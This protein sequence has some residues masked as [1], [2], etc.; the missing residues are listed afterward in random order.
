MYFTLAVSAATAGA[1][2]ALA[3]AARDADPRIMPLPGPARVAWQAADGR[4]AIL[5]W[6]H[7]PA[8]QPDGRPRD[9]GSAGQPADARSQ[10]GTIWAGADAVHARTGLAR[11]DPVYRA[12]V[13]GAVVLS[14]RAS[15]AAAVTGRL[16]DTDPVLVGAFLSLG[17]PVGAA[18]PFR[19]VYALAAG[20]RARAAGG[21]LRVHADPGGGAS[22][23]NGGDGRDGAGPAAVARALTE[24]VRPLAGTELSL[25]GGK[26]SRLVAAALV[27]AGVPFRARTH[28]FA[29]HPDVI[30]AAM[31][32][33]RLGLDHTVTEPAAPGAPGPAEVLGRLRAAVLVS[34]GMLSAFENIGRPDPPA[35]DGGACV[36][37]AGGHGGEL[38][39]GG[40]AQPAWER[41]WSAAAAP[42][43]FRRMTTRRLGLLRRG[44]ARAYL[45]A[46]GPSAAALAR[47]PLRGL[48]EFYL[49]NRAG[50]WSAAARQAYLLRSPLAQPLFADPVVRAARAVALRDRLSDR[51]HREVLAQLC[52][53]L[54]GI[55]LAGRPWQGEA[56]SPVT[57]VTGSGGGPDWRRDLGPALA[58][59]LRGYV[60]DSGALFTV[61]SRPAAERVLRLPLADP[62][63]AW[64]LATLAALMSGDWLSARES[65]TAPVSPGRT[66][67]R[68]ARSTAPPPRG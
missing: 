2:A 17:Y 26:D 28:G 12:E 9:G 14:D 27:A 41:R 35:P 66:A 42:E 25:T 55:P 10:A 22:V 33:G 68:P 63:A 60:L 15:W 34:D 64:A 1:C 6:G 50:R 31:I 45:A 39:R 23:G 54:L 51:L 40:Y 37:Q 59:F 11:V 36:V 38:L 46:L 43:L 4:A 52:P 13:P 57:V 3:A 24:A 44:P 62:Q 56:S 65:T 58:G 61:V 20:R 16:R 47:G 49:V 67:S 21:T 19:G 53:A 29:G 48:D 30:V 8:E 18:T 32:A 7:P 5:H